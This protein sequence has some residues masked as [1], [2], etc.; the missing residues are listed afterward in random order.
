MTDK[1]NGLLLV[2][3]DPPPATEEEFHAWYD[4]EHLPERA[5]LPGFQSAIRFVAVS[6]YPRHLALYDMDSVDAVETPEYLAISGAN[7]SAWTR[8]VSAR[9]NVTRLVTEQI[10]PGTA[11]TERAA[12]LLLMRFRD[13]DA[14]EADALVAAVCT[15]FEPM[16]ETL[17]VRVFAV[18]GRPDYLAAISFAPPPED[19]KLTGLGSFG[20]TLDLVNMYVRRDLSA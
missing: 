9:S 4:N 14:G 17:A 5:A 13:I 16:A 10:Y 12:R 20:K 2:T 15:H 18:Q 3:M 11:A 8:R 7:A 6:G 19:L 1:R